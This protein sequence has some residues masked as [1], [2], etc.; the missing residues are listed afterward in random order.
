MKQEP[1]LASKPRYE[2]L[3]GLRGVAAII[4]LLYH[5]FD[6]YSSGEP[7]TAI[8]NHG[9][10]AVDFFFILSGYVI[11]YAYDERWSRM[12]Y[13]DFFKRR[14]IRL[15]PMIVISTLIGVAFF[16]FGRGET[17]PLIS[18]T[19]FDIL[20]VCVILSVL[21]IPAP[22]SMDIRG[23]G[24]I[25]ALNGNAWTLYYE[26]FANILYALVIRK[27]S[28]VVLCLF[29]LLTS[30][31]TLN[32]A[33]NLDIFGV[34]GERTTQAYTMIGGWSLTAESTVI[35]ISR[36]L[37]PF[38]TG[39]LLSRLGWKIKVNNGFEWCSIILV[40]VLI[41][42]RIGGFEHG[43]WNGIYEAIVIIIV[44]PVL[45]AMGAGSTTSDGAESH[46]CKFLGDISYPLYIV[47]Y[48]IVYTLLGGWKAHNPDAPIDQI[49]V[50][51]TAC[52]A[53][54]FFIAYANLKLYDEPVRRWLS[55]H[56]LW[57][58]KKNKS[59]RETSAVV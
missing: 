56:W 27:F 48:P 58:K 1:A 43:L 9:Y 50:V 11:G 28:K 24:E 45:V 52:F 46:A 7:V 16:Y 42:P 2:I 3:D 31:L 26:Y 32:L 36:L 5:H 59:I 38:F 18:D 25:N 6:L 15:H 54:S 39:L 22:M 34:F 13:R 23:W 57:R 33:L 19:G 20:M 53:L 47:Q 40:A 35:G 14:L 44:F 21:M 17:F 51:N 4:V 10:L 29:V 12:S 49:L 41:M 55:E 37:F 30:V 8:I